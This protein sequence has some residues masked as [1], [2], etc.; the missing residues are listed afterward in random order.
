MCFFPASTTIF[1]LNDLSGC[2]LWLEVEWLVFLGTLL[3]NAL[4]IAVRSCVRH[5][6]TL[7]TVPERK[8][9]PNIDTIMAIVDVTNTFNAQ[10]IPLIVS[11]F[12]YF[13]RNGKNESNVSFQLTQILFSNWISAICVTFVVFVHWK[14]GPEWWTKNDRSYKI[15]RVMIFLNF[16]LLPSINLGITIFIFLLPNFKLI[17][18]PISSYILFYS[19]V[20]VHRLIE[21][22]TLI[23]RSIILDAQIFLEQRD[24]RLN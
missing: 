19:V 4:F 18:Q 9:I 7:V 17:G 10:I 8:K 11:C 20:C 6:I 3:S 22:V 21:F 14:K 5:K 24:H 12:L 13:Q 1:E 15:W 23:R 16:F 2:Y